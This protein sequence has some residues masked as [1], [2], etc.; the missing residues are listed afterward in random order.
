MFIKI[1]T[2]TIISDAMGD[3]VC[4]VMS[5]SNVGVCE[6]TDTSP[7]TQNEKKENSVKFCKD[8]TKQA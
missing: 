5:S 1:V 4:G 3:S 6:A 8:K 7:H 2:I